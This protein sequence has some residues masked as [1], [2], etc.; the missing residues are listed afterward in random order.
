M[1]KKSKKTKIN[2]SS[3]LSSP[4]SE[5]IF[6]PACFAQTRLRTKWAQVPRRTHTYMHAC[7]ICNLS[8]YDRKMESNEQVDP[9]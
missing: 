1:E 8:S 2:S 9:T 5:R 7:T 4:P 3:F 6:I